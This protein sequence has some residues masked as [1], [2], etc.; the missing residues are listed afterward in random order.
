MRIIQGIKNRLIARAGKYYRLWMYTFG[1]YSL[2]R[3]VTIR[4]GECKKCGACC[5]GCELLDKKTMLCKNFELAKLMGCVVFPI[6]IF[7]QKRVGVQDKCGFYWGK[8][9]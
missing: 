1:W 4:K 9:R 6:S 2:K 5:S 8:D 3:S 7:D